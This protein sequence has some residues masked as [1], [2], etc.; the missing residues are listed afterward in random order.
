MDRPRSRTGEGARGRPP[1]REDRGLGGRP[2]RG[3]RGCVERVA[4]LGQPAPVPVEV[5]PF[6]EAVCARALRALGADPVPR[7]GVRHRR[8]N[9][10]LD[11]GS[12][13]STTPGGWRRRSARSRA[14]SS[15]ACSSAWPR[16]PTWVAPTG[17]RCSGRS[18][19][20]C[21]S[22]LVDRVV[23]RQPYSRSGRPCSGR[24]RRSRAPPPRSTRTRAPRRAGQLRGPRQRVAVAGAAASF[25]CTCASSTSGTSVFAGRCS[26]FEHVT[27]RA[28]PACRR[29]ALA[30]N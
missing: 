23:L 24:R 26:P 5:V 18:G 16:W 14:W 3:G 12:G 8:G 7:E 9:R 19:E 27:R 30:A 15:T 21:G 10:I 6:G 13:R 20:P 17:S 28:R 25:R 2:V 11:C 22:G 4:R 29:R 1:A